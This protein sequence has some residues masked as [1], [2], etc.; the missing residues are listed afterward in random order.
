MVDDRLIG[1]YLLYR[2]KSGDAVVEVVVCWSWWFTN[3]QGLAI[4]EG[5]RNESYDV[6]LVLQDSKIKVIKGKAT[7]KEEII[8]EI[9]IKEGRFLSS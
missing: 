9:T 8:G 5:K 4:I 7:D 1:Y 3:E 6:W 2:Q